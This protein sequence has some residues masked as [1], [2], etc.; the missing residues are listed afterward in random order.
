MVRDNAHSVMVVINR[1]AKNSL[2]GYHRFRKHKPE[3]IFEVARLRAFE[4]LPSVKEKEL[5]VAILCKIISLRLIEK[6]DNMIVADM[7]L[8]RGVRYYMDK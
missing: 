8:A 1:V 2:Q 5:E 4:E 6:S 7:L 3:E